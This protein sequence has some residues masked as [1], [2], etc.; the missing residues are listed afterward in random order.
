LEQHESDGLANTAKLT[1][2]ILDQTVPGDWS[3][4][5]GTLYKGDTLINGNTDIVD[6]IGSTTG[7]YCTIFQDNVRVTTNIEKDGQRIIGTTAS[8]EV[9]AS[10]INQKQTYLG[11]AMVLDTECITCYMPISDVH[12]TVIGMFF[13]GESAADS[14]RSLNASHNRILLITVILFLVSAAAIY[15]I[16][17]LLIS[18]L[19]KYLR[20]LSS[21]AAAIST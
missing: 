16:L 3:I 1:M 4:Q 5:N 6:E 21:S 13:V 9:T 8:D 14:L 12:G 15:L 11:T 18:P 2:Q 10:V 19:K 20:P 7:Y 17:G